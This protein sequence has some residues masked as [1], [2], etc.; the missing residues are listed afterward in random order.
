MKAFDGLISRLDIAKETISELE[1]RLIEISQTEMQ[2]TTKSKQARN[3]NRASKNCREITIG[4]C[5]KIRRE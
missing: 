4:I 2:R 3:Q 5:D 1:E